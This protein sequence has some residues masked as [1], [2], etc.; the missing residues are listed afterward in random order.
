MFF[1]R[2]KTPER[3]ADVVDKS[4]YQDYKQEL[5][6]DFNTRCGYCNDH[7]EW[8][9]SFYEIDHFIPKTLLNEDE[10]TDYTNLV[11]SCRYCNSSKSKKWPTNDRYKCNDGRVG[12]TDPCNK[13]YDSQFVRNSMG[14]II[15]QSVLGKWMYRELKLYLNRHSI[16]WQIEKI[17]KILKEFKRLKLYRND[18][19]KELYIRMSNYFFDMIQELKEENDK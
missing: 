16:L 5:R 17:E 15:P 11:F 3:R 10:Y 8:R 12:F 2:E 19:Y 6:E 18:A 14:E 9:N 4:R 1:F 7:E 13:A